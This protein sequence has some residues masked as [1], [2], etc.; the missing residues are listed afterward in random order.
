MF[1]LSWG[2]D[3][4]HPSN[5]PQKTPEEWDQAEP[6]YVVHYLDMDGAKMRVGFVDGLPAGEKMIRVNKISGLGKR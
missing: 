1:R 6:D 3:M 2:S 5:Q 4:N